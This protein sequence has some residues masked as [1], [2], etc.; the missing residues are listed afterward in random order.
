MSSKNEDAT[1]LEELWQGQFGDQYTLRNVD[2]GDE[3]MPFW[4]DVLSGIEV[5]RVL[6]V[7]CNLGS[8]LR[9]LSSLLP[10]RQVYGIDVNE[11]A[12]AKVR[13]SVPGVNASWSPA[14]ELPFRDG[15]FDLVFTT[16]VLIHQP[17]ATLPDVMSEIVRCSK[18]YV[19]AGEYFAE[20]LTEVS[21]RGHQGAL[22]KADFGG[23]YLRLFPELK[24]VRKGFLD[25]AIWD[26]V[27]WW[28][29]ERS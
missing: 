11:S 1:R 19:L 3:R 2:T 29:L 8:N 21:Y 20:Q 17:V 7:G 14:R 4:R 12:L 16:G 23:M 13:A 28:L 5:E 26:Q 9:T 18:R 10:P 25:D 15:Y 22:F 6:E 24:L 27:T